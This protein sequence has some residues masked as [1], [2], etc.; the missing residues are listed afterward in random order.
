MLKTRPVEEKDLPQIEEWIALDKDHRGK[1]TPAFWNTKERANCFAVEDEEGT[2]FY[3]RAEN[4][5]R[6]HIQFAPPDKV[7]R[8]RK[9]VDEFERL[10]RDQAKRT[11]RQIIFESVSKHLIRFLHKRGYYSSPDEQV[12]DL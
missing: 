8:T 4:I 7:D 3:V 5:L 11:Y 10:I 2:I 6:L 9:A 1:S 12:T